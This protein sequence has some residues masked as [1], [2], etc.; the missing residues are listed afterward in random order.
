M[1]IAIESLLKEVKIPKLVEVRQI[2]KTEAI[3]N[4][5]AFIKS[6]LNKV[7][8]KKKICHGDLV[9]I[10][11]GSRGIPY[12]VQVLRPIINIVK[13]LGGKPFIVSAMGSH[14]GGTAIGQKKILSKLGINEKTLKV[15]ILAQMDVVEIGKTKRGVKIYFNRAAYEADKIIVINRIKPHNYFESEVGSGLQKM[16]TIGLGNQKGC[17]YIHRLA[18]TDTKLYKLIEEVAETI[19]KKA[20]ITACIG[21]VENA[22]NEPVKIQ[23]M[24][25]NKVKAQ[26]R[27]LLKL[28]RK[29]FPRL[30][31]E[32]I[33]ILVVDEIGKEISGGGMD[34]I[35]IGN[36]NYRTNYKGV[37]RIKRLVI[38]DLSSKSSGNANGIGLADVTTKNLVKK[39]NYEETYMNLLSS[40]DLA[41]AKV[42]LIMQNDKEAIKAAI[43]T[44]RNTDIRNLKMVRIKNT[45]TL[46]R[47][48][49]SRALRKEVRKNSLLEILGKLEEIKF[50]KNGKIV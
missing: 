40:G 37:P 45:K 8:L 3:D 38:L 9:A 25:A 43:Y 2:V 4:I 33:D 31:F 10:T 17:N 1:D 46:I 42:P 12:L 44:L 18:E 50:T 49:V 36:K 22:F 27:R 15:D 13:E 14:G 19:L 47:M 23:A 34:L 28:A 41:P 11:A 26:E 35:V 30:P 7:N 32:D 48:H 16:L 21:I 29:L 6:E 5:E 20:P 39:I 24:N